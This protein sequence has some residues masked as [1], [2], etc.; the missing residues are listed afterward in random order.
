MGSRGVPSL[1]TLAPYLQLGCP[2]LLSEMHSGVHMPMQH[3]LVIGCP[4]L[5][6]GNTNRRDVNIIN[7]HLACRFRYFHCIHSWRYKPVL[8]RYVC[9]RLVLYKHCYQVGY[10]TPYPIGTRGDIII[11]SLPLDGSTIFYHSR[12]PS[13]MHTFQT[14]LVCGREPV[15]KNRNSH[16]IHS[17]N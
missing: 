7:G 5:T 3:H 14:R 16:S 11:G 8:Y 6:T 13:Q 4:P 17:W 12:F 10:R 2:P 9:Q 15:V 1:P